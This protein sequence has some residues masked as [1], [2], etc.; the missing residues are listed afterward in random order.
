MNRR[1]IL[2]FMMVLGWATAALS[3]V[4]FTREDSLTI[5]RMLR[6]AKQEKQTSTLYFARQFIGLPYVAHTL[7]V[8]DEEQL[9][10]NTRELD[11]TTYVEMVL[12]LTI[13]ARQGKTS[14]EDFVSTIRST[15]YRGGV[16]NRYPSRIH[17]FSDWIIQNTGR[18]VVEELQSPNPPFTAVQNVRVSYMTEHPQAYKA[19]KEHP[20]FLSVILEQEQQL[21][22]KTFR[23]IPMKQLKKLNTKLMRQT[24][25]DGDVIAITSS[26]PGLDI[27]HLG[28]AVWKPDGLHLLNA[29]SVHKKVEEDPQLFRI[30]MQ[31]RSQVTGIRV[32]RLK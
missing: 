18:G 8:N 30:Y 13:C 12:A 15:R 22:G 32:V 6:Q 27:A 9:V 19:L 5:C 24:V 28:F 4:T 29:S 2:V 10:I 1:L 23:Y 3:Q 31:N 11:C 21:T 26:K 17:Y 25:K 20:E 14:F 7:E 16:V